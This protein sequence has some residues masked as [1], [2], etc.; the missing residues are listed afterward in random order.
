MGGSVVELNE[1][2]CEGKD[3][4][5]RMAI[6]AWDSPDFLGGHSGEGDLFQP[7]TPSEIPIFVSNRG[8]KFFVYESGELD[9][10]RLSMEGR[11][12]GCVTYLK[13][14]VQLG[15]Y[16]LLYEVE[17]AE[18]PSCGEGETDWCVGLDAFEML[19]KTLDR[20]MSAYI[21]YGLTD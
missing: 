3:L 10:R 18:P 9:C 5:L 1:R 12:D 21:Y 13:L 15:R 4:I 19:W 16:E 11:G 6:W 14:W 8:H 7:V 17:R 20:T 2:V